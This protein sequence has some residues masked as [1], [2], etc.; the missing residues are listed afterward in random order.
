MEVE[1]LKTIVERGF[2]DLSDRMQAGFADVDSRMQA[3]FAR[4]DSR[5]EGVEARLTTL[6]GEVHK[7]GILVERLEGNIKQVAEGVE[8]HHAEFRLHV[9]DTDQRFE[10][11]HSVIRHFGDKRRKRT[12]GRARPS[13]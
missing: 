8:M 4:V 11:I 13:R 12:T 6:E 5:F 2:K 3:G 9:A 7:T 1:E 10:K